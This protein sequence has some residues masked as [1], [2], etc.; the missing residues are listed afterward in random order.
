M[1]LGLP[2]DRVERPGRARRPRA[3]SHPAPGSLGSPS[4][5]T[6]RG[7]LQW[8]DE[9]AL[10]RAKAPLTGQPD[11][12]VMSRLDGPGLRPRAPLGSTVPRLK[13]AATERRGAQRLLTRR[14]ALDRRGSTVER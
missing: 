12:T 14:P 9:A 8:L 5:P 13:D 10:R 3:G 7:C 11:E 4:A 1:R 6:R 2:G